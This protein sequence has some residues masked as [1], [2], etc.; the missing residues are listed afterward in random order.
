ME[1]SFKAGPEDDLLH[2]KWMEKDS[3]NL[4]IN[5]DWMTIRRP[6]YFALLRFSVYNLHTFIGGVTLYHS[7]GLILGDF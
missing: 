1:N 6:I 2:S 5:I 7:E 3:D 4:L